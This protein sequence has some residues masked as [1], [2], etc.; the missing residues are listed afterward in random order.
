VRDDENFSVVHV[1]HDLVGVVLGRNV[2]F[3]T[4]LVGAQVTTQLQN[5]LK[6]RLPHA[7]T[8]SLT[9]QDSSPTQRTAVTPI[10]EGMIHRQTIVC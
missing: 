2:A 1:R 7:V 4:L 9:N 5:E 3:T 6:R 8:H 10:S